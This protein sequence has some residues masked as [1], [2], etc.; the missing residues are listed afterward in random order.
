MLPMVCRSERVM[1]K[2]PRN[3]RIAALPMVAEG[4]AMPAKARRQRP[5]GAHCAEIHLASDGSRDRG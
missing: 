4:P 3:M 2:K 1:P 5:A